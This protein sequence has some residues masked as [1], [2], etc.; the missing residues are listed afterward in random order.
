[1]AD[2]KQIDLEIYVD[3]E[4]LNETVFDIG[5]YDLRHVG[6]MVKLAEEII[7]KLEDKGITIR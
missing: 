1:M 7:E 4:P 5:A 2:R 3:G 6:A